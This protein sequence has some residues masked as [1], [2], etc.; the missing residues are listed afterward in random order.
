MLNYI[1]AELY[2]TSRRRVVYAVLLLLLL[3]ELLVCILEGYAT[4]FSEMVYLLSIMMVLGMY[5][6]IPLAY[7]SLSNPLQNNVLKNEV[8]F[9]LPR[10]RIYLGK[11]FTAGIICV[12]TC[13]AMVG[14]YLGVTWLGCPHGGAEAEQTALL[15]LGHILAAS[16]PLW[17]GMLGV[18]VMVF[19]LVR[20]GGGTVLLFLL[21]TLVPFVMNLFT[22]INLPVFQMVGRI[23]VGLLPTEHFFPVNQET[24][25]I[26][27]NWILGMGW[28]G[29]STALGLYL[30]QRKEL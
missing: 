9:G 21:L 7:L 27:Y 8:S 10:S 26:A 29:G 5:L 13:G 28:L 11:L 30:F 23:G 1:R 4:Q 12:L 25:A 3:G 19:L 2:R 15:I 20:S 6:V 14:F 17:L 16:L 24:P 18:S 22:E